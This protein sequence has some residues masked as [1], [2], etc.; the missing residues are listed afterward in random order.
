MRLNG[1]TMLLCDCAGSMTLD[2]TALAGILGAEAP[3]GIAHALCREQ[4]DRIRQAL[5][6]GHPVVVGCT[7]ESALF[8]ELRAEAGEDAVLLT[9]NP[10][11]R[12]GW[13]DEHAKALPKIAALLAEAMV[14]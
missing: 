9:A 12:A 1:K 13:S 8:E 4:Q 2:G 7:Q 11:E 5:R 10:R 6:E 3:A 14:P